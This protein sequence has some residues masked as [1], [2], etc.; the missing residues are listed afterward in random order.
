[1]VSS[2]IIVSEDTPQMLQ[3][4]M[5][6]YMQGLFQGARGCIDW[7]PDLLVNIRVE[8]FIVAPL[9]GFGQLQKVA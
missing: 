2:A 9:V 4:H 5:Y 6:M 1:M 7:L 8:P 3:I